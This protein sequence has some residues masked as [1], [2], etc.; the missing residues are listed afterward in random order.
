[1]HRFNIPLLWV[2]TYSGRVSAAEAEEGRC[3]V[4]LIYDAADS[5]RVKSAL[6]AN[7]AT[8]STVLEGLASASRRLMAALGTEQLSGQ[9]YSAIAALFAQVIVPSISDAKS[10]IAAIRKDLEKYTAEDSKVSRFGVLKEDELK[11]QLAAT[12]RQRDAT[13]CLMETNR[14]AAETL[15]AVPML[16]EALQVVNSQLEMVLTQLEKD[17]RDL[18]DR[19]QLLQ[20]FAE[21]TKGLFQIDLQGKSVASLVAAS[22]AKADPQKVWTASELM[23]VLTVLGPAEVERVLARNPGLAQQFWDAPPPAEAVATWWKALAPAAREK[24]CQAAPT[25]I[26][27]LPG[28]DADTRVHA[29]MIQFQ[30][31]LYDT[32]IDPGSP[33]GIVIGDILEALN[34]GRFSGPMLD[35][36]KL[37]KAEKPPRGLLAYNSTR[38]PPLAAVAIGET[39]AEKSGKVTWAVPGMASGLGEPHQLGDWTSAVANV[40]NEQ[41]DLEAGVPHLVVAWIGYDPPPAFLPDT[42]VLEG[43]RARAGASR[44]TAE[45]DGQWAA[46]TILGENQQPYTAVLGHS[47]GTTVATDAISDGGRLAHPVQSVVLLASAGVERNIPDFSYLRV[48]GGM[49]RVYATQS[50]RDEVADA[51]R[52]GSGRAD[53]RA[54]SFGAKVYS[55]EG[56]PAQKLEPTDGHDVIGR[57]SDRDGVGVFAHATAGHGYLDAGTESLK[58]TAAATLG[59]D[60]KINGGTHLGKN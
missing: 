15:A 59:L 14:V 42:S 36:E 28:L 53:P 30:R 56:D 41:Q 58:N 12:T 26:G 32:S 2:R 49:S 52:F 54:G 45:L 24:W 34:V 39:S 3:G 7:L 60:E 19:L 37:A 50:S 55:S 29:N 22:A 10:D 27:N 9:G 51:G 43:D 21:A 16:G 38:Q 40:Y 8:A 5:S 18:G 1:M 17:V 35:Y 47:Y 31:D 25:I 20:A 48:D 11:V 13:V 4:G 44:L 33:R 57:G 6:S 46:D 23:N